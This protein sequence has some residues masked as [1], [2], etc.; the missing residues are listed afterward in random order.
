MVLARDLSSVAQWLGSISAHED[1]IKKYIPQMF[2]FFFFFFFF[3]FEIRN[4]NFFSFS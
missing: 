4:L 2:F 3:N 1:K